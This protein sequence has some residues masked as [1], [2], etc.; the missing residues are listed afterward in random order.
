MSL[1]A[2]LRRS[3]VGAIALLL[4]APAAPALAAPGDDAADLRECLLTC[5]SPAL[6]ALGDDLST[7]PDP[8]EVMVPSVT[9]DLAGHRLEAAGIRL[10]PGTELT[11]TDSGTG[12][13]LESRA[14]AAGGPGI[15]TT[16][17]VLRV[18]GGRVVAVARASGDPY[19]GPT[20]A[21]IGGAYREAG[22]TLVVTGG[23]VHAEGA[24][25]SA[26][27]GNGSNQT[28][29]S[30]P[31][32][33][34]GGEVTAIGGYSGAGIGGGNW[35]SPGPVTIAGG[36]VT[37]QGG[38]FG[39]AIGGG[40]DGGA[41]GPVVVSGGELVATGGYQAAGIGST[42][43]STERPGADVTIGPGATV[44]AIGTGRTAIGADARDDL[45]AEFGRVRIDG[46]LFLP[47][48]FVQIADSDAPNAEMT[49]SPTGR[50]LGGAGDPAEGARIQGAGQIE[51]R[52]AI[53][54]AAEHVDVDVLGRSYRVDFDGQGRGGDASHRL[55][56]ADFASG[57]RAVPPP[58]AGS[59]W[60]TRG[61]GTGAWFD[62][63]TPVSEHTTIF[64]ATP[65]SVDTSAIPTIG[66]VGVPLPLAGIR[67]LDPGGSD[68]GSPVAWTSDAA[69]DL[70]DAGSLVPAGVGPRRL[71][72]AATVMGVAVVS[73]V[74]VDIAAAAPT[75]PTGLRALP[76]DG[77]ATLTWSAPPSGGEAI[78][79]Y[80]VEQRID[81]GPWEAERSIGVGTRTTLTGLRNGGVYEYRVAAVDRAGPGAFSET[82]AATP[83]AFEPSFTSE[84]A[85]L[86]DGSVLEPGANITVSAAKLPAGSRV[87]V[88]L[89]SLQAGIADATVAHDGT[90]VLTGTIPADSAEGVD[91]ITATL[92]LPDGSHG[93][94]STLAVAIRS[95]S[96]GG[97]PV[98]AG[99]TRDRSPGYGALAATGVPPA[100]YPSALAA[101]L[102]LVGL[103][104]ALIVARR[105]FES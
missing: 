96:G 18:D 77:E 46:D 97:D 60:N 32:T 9:L 28:S 49:V 15:Q 29:A 14:G 37:A 70:I 6:I 78:V 79:G 73:S 4:V 52:G 1:S 103:G 95:T 2:L 27:I 62:A 87:H 88:A 33:V 85:K 102:L 55:F 82:A 57:H 63:T 19:T 64:A 24:Y 65:A 80:V 90:V 45:S 58:P 25:Q 89:R 41:G 68:L 50:I 17:A 31:T 38:D 21:G 69:G 12:G 59:L 43:Y 36:R 54:L 99:A 76:G 35:S 100:Q 40:Y 34:S 26:G 11:I 10:A 98:D 8:L 66:R 72:A 74:T 56:A 23:Q 101:T 44:T 61:D 7:G 67:V 22:G 104:T 13:T 94:A 83:Y 20:G 71:T 81:G 53:A 91:S 75:A 16:G 105:G 92:T 84:R 39:A 93:G 30:G 48:G 47:S 3:A 51:N 42:R 5:G 86:A